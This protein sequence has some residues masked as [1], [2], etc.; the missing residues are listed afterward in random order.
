M[1]RSLKNKGSV[2]SALNHNK[3]EQRHAE[4]IKNTKQLIASGFLK[5]KIARS[6]K[7]VFKTKI[8]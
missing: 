6:K 5:F 1:M 8:S 4:K 3:E 2:F 7:W